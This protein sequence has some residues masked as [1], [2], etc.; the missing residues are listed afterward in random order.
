MITGHKMRGS[1]YTEILFEAQLVTSGSL[2]GVLSGKAYAKS[3]FCLKTVC[4][5]MER[6]LM[7]QFVEEENILIVDPTAL[8]NMT[9]TCDREHLDEALNDPSTL[10][11]IE[12]YCTYEDKVRKGHLWKTTAFWMTFLDHSHL[13]FML[14]HSVKTNNICDS[15]LPRSHHQANSTSGY[16]IRKAST[17]AEPL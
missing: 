13:V 12:R 17:T 14:F 3:L 9:Q 16:V 6:L 7:E 2:K 15:S 10:T 8:L 1:G 4:E 5:A 11:L